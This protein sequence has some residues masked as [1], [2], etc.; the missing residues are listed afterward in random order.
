[1]T[2]MLNSYVSFV[3]GEAVEKIEETS[4]NDLIE[5]LCKSNYSD[6][7]KIKYNLEKSIKTL[8]RPIQIKQDLL[9]I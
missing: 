6:N 5:I 3:R 9:K 8:C 2:A 1:M 4:I 7:F